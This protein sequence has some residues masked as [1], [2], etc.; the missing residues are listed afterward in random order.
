[1][2]IYISSLSPQKV[3]PGLPTAILCS[4]NNPEYFLNHLQK[5]FS[6]F[7]NKHGI[8]GFFKLFFPLFIV[9]K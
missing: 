9:L 3:P 1:M 8:K 5:V 4:I 7:K 6:G 2:L